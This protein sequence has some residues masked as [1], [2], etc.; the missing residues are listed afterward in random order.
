MVKNPADKAVDARDMGLISESDRSL[1][2][3]MAAPIFLPVKSHEQRS[4]AGWSPRGH[5]VRQTERS[6]AHTHTHTHT[7]THLLQRGNY[8]LMD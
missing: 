7:H 5:R 6:N 3:K 1:E 8:R 4:L 2:E